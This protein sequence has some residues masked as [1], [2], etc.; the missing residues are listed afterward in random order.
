MLILERG[1]QAEAEQGVA[2]AGA[3]PFVWRRARTDESYLSASEPTV[4]FGLG[5][6][7]GPVDVVVEWLGG[8]RQTW[9]NVAV[10][11]VIELVEGK[12]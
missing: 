2:A 12:K 10:D 6:N 11:R 3:G 5:K 9:K 8:Q 4:H 7:T 1:R